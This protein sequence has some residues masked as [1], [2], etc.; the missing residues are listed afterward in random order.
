[1]NTWREQLA[2]YEIKQP[3][4]QLDRPVFD[5]SAVT[6]ATYKE[7]QG[8]G[9]SIYKVSA[10]MNYDWQRDPGGDAGSY[11]CTFYDDRGS[12][13]G[14]CLTFQSALDIVSGAEENTAIDELVFYRSGT[15]YPGYRLSI[16]EHDI[17]PVRDV[18][19]KTFSEILYRI[20]QVMA[21]KKGK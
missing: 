12:G 2:D 6:T 10:L 4:P 13:I 14:A 15:V 20:K 11:Y 5:N 21:P 9:F 19:Q 7:L 8:E 1:M 17:L 16:D 3:F 18:P